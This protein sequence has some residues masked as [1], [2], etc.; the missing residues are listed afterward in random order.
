MNNYVMLVVVMGCPV[1]VYALMVVNMM[2]EP[3]RR[4]G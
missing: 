2:F 1:G 3:F 4:D